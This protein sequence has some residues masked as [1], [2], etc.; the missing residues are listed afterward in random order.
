MN[1]ATIYIYI[2]YGPH[3]L[4]VVLS[5]VNV[6]PWFP[7]SISPLFFTNGGFS[8]LNEAVEAPS[9]RSSRGYL[10]LYPNQSAL[11]VVLVV[12]CCFF[13]PFL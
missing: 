2:P 10:H 12:L 1:K 11:L 13:F 9:Q 4:G 3:A 5:V 7:S 6:M 8:K